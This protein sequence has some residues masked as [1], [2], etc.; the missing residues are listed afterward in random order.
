MRYKDEKEY[1]REARRLLADGWRI[2]AQSSQR[3]N[4]KMG[5]TMLKA[6]VFLPWAMMRPSRKGDPVTVTWLRG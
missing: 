5:S 4:V 3:G 1:E 2:E 6:G